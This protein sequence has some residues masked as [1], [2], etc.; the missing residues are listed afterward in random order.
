MRT[1]RIQRGFRVVDAVVQRSTDFKKLIQVG[2]HDAQV[3][4][5]LQQRDFCALCPIE[6]A[7]VE[8]EQT[9]IAV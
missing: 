6:H 8:C 2:R 9:Q 5:S 4:Q 1:R 3:A 7:R